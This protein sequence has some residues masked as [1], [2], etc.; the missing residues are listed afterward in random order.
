MA[1]CCTCAYE[2]EVKTRAACLNLHRNLS[3]LADRHTQGVFY[4]RGQ[5][6]VMRTNELREANP[7]ISEKDWDKMLRD[8]FGKE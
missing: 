8:E 3:R 2:H 5:K 6:E 1:K 7:D 4:E